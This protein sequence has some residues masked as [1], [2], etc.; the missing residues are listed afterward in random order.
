MTDFDAHVIRSRA[1]QQRLEDFMA[2]IELLLVR[3]AQ[4][5]EKEEAK[6]DAAES[7]KTRKPA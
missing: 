5:L 3:V 6:Q 2:R 7:R 4:L 1:H